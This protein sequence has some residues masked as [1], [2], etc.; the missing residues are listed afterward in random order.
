MRPRS[1]KNLETLATA[2]SRCAATH[3]AWCD[4]ARCSANPASQANGCRPGV[5][6]EHRCAPVWL[7]LT[8]ASRLP[9]SGGEAC[10]TEAVAP[11]PC[12]TDLPGRVGNDEVF[13]SVEY[14]ARVLSALYVLANAAGAGRGDR[15]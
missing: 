6:G 11:W 2:E 10:L 7:D 5:G 14:A 13:V 3:P 1:Q 15:R 9:G 12:S 4:R 8:C